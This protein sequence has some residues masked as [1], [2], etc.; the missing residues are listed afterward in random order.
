[1][2]K[3]KLQNQC[4]VRD[5]KKGVGNEILIE[6]LIYNVKNNLINTINKLTYI[7]YSLLCREFVSGVLRGVFNKWRWLLLLVLHSGYR[8]AQLRAP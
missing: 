3:G 7:Y 2:E 1:M 5:Q 8:A 6:M 4:L